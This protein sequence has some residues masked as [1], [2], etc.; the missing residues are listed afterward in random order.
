M[1]GVGEQLRGVPGR[2]VEILV[3]PKMSIL[4]KILLRNKQENV[5]KKGKQQQ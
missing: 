2:C 4:E 5:L 1:H 3:S